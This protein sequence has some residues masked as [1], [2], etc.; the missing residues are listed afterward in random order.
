MRDDPEDFND[1][2]EDMSEED[3][4]CFLTEAIEEHAEE[5]DL[6]STSVSTYADAGVLTRNRGLVVRIGESEFQVTIVRSR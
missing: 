3:F 4:Q 2:L 5:N 6:P 1:G